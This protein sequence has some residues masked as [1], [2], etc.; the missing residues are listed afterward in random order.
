MERSRQVVV[1]AVARGHPVYGLTTAVAERKRIR[2][3]ADAQR[4]FNRSVI[5]GHRVAQGPVASEAVVRA[6]LLCLAN[7]LATGYAGVRPA[8]VEW[9]VEALN[10]ERAP[11]VRTL[12]SLGEAD[13]GPMSD[14]ASDLLDAVDITL[15]ANEGLALLDNNAFSTACAALALDGTRR[16][17]ESLEAATALDF[18]A[19][20]ANP[21]VLDEVVSRSGRHTGRSRSR[22]ILTGLLEGSS[23]YGPGVPRNLQ[24]PLSF[25]CVPQVHGATWEAFFYRAASSR[26]K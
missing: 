9:I 1:E 17:L 24:D 22:R 3:D 13:L 14:L 11:R 21:S 7:G 2:I 5:A 10:S 23:L 4:R 6:T 20:A 12:G 18:E 15:E 26:Q 16:T 8:L 25:R 19:F